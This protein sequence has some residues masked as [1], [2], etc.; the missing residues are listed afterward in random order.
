MRCGNKRVGL[1]VA[2]NRKYIDRGEVERR[3]EAYEIDMAPLRREI[4]CPTS[5]ERSA[6]VSITDAQWP[7]G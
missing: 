1:R 7:G 3:I 6:G 5:N 4:G 2:K